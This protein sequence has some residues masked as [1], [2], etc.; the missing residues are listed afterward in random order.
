MQKMKKIFSSLIISMLMILS[1]V[2]IVSAENQPPIADAGGPYE[3]FTGENITF[4]GSNSVDPDGNNSNLTYKWNF[5]DGNKMLVTG[6]IV[7]YSYSEHGV[8]TVNLTVTDED[9]NETTDSTTA[10][11]KAKPIAE[12]SY[13]PEK[14]KPETEIT[15]D[16]SASDDPDGNNSNLTYEWDLG[17]GTT[18]ENITFTY[19]YSNEGEYIVTLVVTDEQGYNDTMT[20]TISIVDN[21]PPTIEIT[22]P[23]KAKVYILGLPVLPR[24]NGE[25]PLIVGGIS[26]QANATD[27]DDGIEKVEF[28]INDE[29]Q[30]TVNESKKDSTI[31]QWRW[32]RWSTLDREKNYT[33]KVIS[34]DSHGESA[35]SEIAVQ[36]YRGLKNTLI[37]GAVAAAV[38]LAVPALQK[39]LGKTNETDDGSPDENLENQA[40]TAMINASSSVKVNEEITLDASESNDDKM[41]VSYEWDLGDGTN[42]TGETITHK[43]KQPGDYTVTLVVTDEEG[44]Q[45]TMTMTINVEKTKDKSNGTPGFGITTFMLVI[46]LF[47]AIMIYKKKH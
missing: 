4:D 19:N 24:V 20:K 43:Y 9:G 36:H 6:K 46:T 28:Y 16:A 40:P 5:G 33:I 15:F 14:P 10:T 11:I 7:N 32:K 30:A 21:Y 41:I 1:A 2:T 35:E 44:E 42:I 45:D 31:Y 27:P 25:V 39:L 17:D 47:A 29:L 23:S 3:G 18:Q 13:T 22:K 38:G 12:F 37:I 34:Y 8:Y 26:I